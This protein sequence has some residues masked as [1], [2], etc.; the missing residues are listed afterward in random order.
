VSNTIHFYDVGVSGRMRDFCRDGS[1]VPLDD[2]LA[3]VRS[4]DAAKY[5]SEGLLPSLGTFE[6]DPLCRTRTSRWE[7]A[8]RSVIYAVSGQLASRGE[9]LRGRQYVDSLPKVEKQTV[10]KDFV[11]TALP[12]LLVGFDL[13]LEPSRMSG[14]NLLSNAHS[15]L[16][17]LRSKKPVSISS[18]LCAHRESSKVAAHQLL[19][20]IHPRKIARS[21]NLV[22][23]LARNVAEGPV[24]ISWYQQGATARAAETLFPEMF[25][26]A[27][28]EGRV[29]D[30]LLT[31]AAQFHQV[32][33]FLAE[34]S[35]DSVRHS[36]VDLDAF[37]RE[38]ED[39][40]AAG[41][42]ALPLR[43]IAETLARP[44]VERLMNGRDLGRTGLCDRSL[45]IRGNESRARELEGI[46]W[47]LPGGTS[48]AEA[49]RSVIDWFFTRASNDSIAKATYETYFYAM[50][51]RRCAEQGE[52]AIG[53]DRDFDHYQ[54]QAWN[55]GWERGRGAASI[56]PSGPGPTG[57][58][59]LYARRTPKEREGGI[60]GQISFR[61]FWREIP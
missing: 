37:A 33:T 10:D 12:Y 20:T 48:L 34:H 51:G 44:A 17:S 59:L 29:P 16:S 18:F 13:K 61:Q 24:E 26:K 50:W 25:A 54:I 39:S 35:T 41:T 31:L 7:R 4:L 40:V 42:E 1:L 14:S 23:A 38:V 46:G 9:I 5:D 57:A 52:I 49:T 15:V 60:L 2:L 58:P 11:T 8:V 28:R 55:V 56:N 53:L 43:T 19:E 30:L 21:V 3:Y 32:E 6:F 27:L 22:H 47:E 36:L 45:D